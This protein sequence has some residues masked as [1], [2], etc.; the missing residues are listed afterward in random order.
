[1]GRR[2]STM[3][4]FSE[5]GERPAWPEPLFKV[6]D[7]VKRIVPSNDL[8]KTIVWYLLGFGN[9][10]LMIFAFYDM[11]LFLFFKSTAF[12]RAC[13]G[14]AS[15]RPPFTVYYTLSLFTTLSMKYAYWYTR[16]TLYVLMII[17][18]I[19]TRRRHYGRDADGALRPTVGRAHRSV[20]ARVDGVHRS[21]VVHFPAQSEAQSDRRDRQG[22]A[23]GLRLRLQTRH[24]PRNRRVPQS[25]RTWAAHINIY[26]Y[27]FFFCL[28]YRHKHHIR[29][30]Y[31]VSI[32]YEAWHKNNETFLMVPPNRQR[33]QYN[34]YWNIIKGPTHDQFNRAVYLCK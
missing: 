14:T 6:I 27:I 30:V 10:F 34:D 5:T 9:I 24:Q 7:H 13:V 32:V 1:M 2:P 26:I 12:P 4:G 20:H 25:P 23:L 31:T 22:A 15:I 11:R 8:F 19:V 3:E 18:T 29:A 17:M 33:Y 21:R 28:S 16:S